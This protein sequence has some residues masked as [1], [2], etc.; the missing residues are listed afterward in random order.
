MARQKPPTPG[1]HRDVREAA[2][3]AQKW[4]SRGLTLSVLELIR[5]QAL[6]IGPVSRP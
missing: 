4:A 2:T 6:D 3:L 5:T 1:R